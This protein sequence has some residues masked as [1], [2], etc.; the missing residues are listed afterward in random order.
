MCEII[1]AIHLK[2]LNIKVNGLLNADRKLNPN[3][4]QV[5][6]NEKAKLKKKV[7]LPFWSCL[8]YLPQGMSQEDLTHSMSKLNIY[9]FNSLLVNVKLRAVKS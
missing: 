8:V 7:M 9:E 5:T 4:N 6:E 3:N 1:C 2:Y